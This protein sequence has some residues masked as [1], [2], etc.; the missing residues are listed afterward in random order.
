MPE[1]VTAT[2]PQMI[3]T[4]KSSYDVA[5]GNARKNMA[6]EGS[7]PKSSMKRSIAGGMCRFI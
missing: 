6:V 2:C 5:N 1:S 7:L 4:L 3:A